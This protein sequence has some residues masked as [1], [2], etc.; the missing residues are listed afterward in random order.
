MTTIV[1][2]TDANV[3]AEVYESEYPV[4]VDFWATWCG[5]CKVVE[6]ALKAVAE[7][8]EGRLKVV[9]VNVDDNPEFAAKMR[10]HSIP[11]LSIFRGGQLSATKNGA[12][13]LNDLRAFV[14]AHL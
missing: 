5:P 12:V 6:P 14:N 10:I 2:V 4:L 8:F 9:K 11:T 13:S 7:E 3:E 1:H